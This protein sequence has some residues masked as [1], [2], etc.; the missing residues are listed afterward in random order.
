MLIT[1]PVQ[2]TF[3]TIFALFTCSPHCHCVHFH[4]LKA[5]ISSRNNHK[6][7]LRNP[8]GLTYEDYKT[9]QR[10][11]RPKQVGKLYYFLK[12]AFCRSTPS[13]LTFHNKSPGHILCVT[14]DQRQLSQI[15][16]IMNSF[17]TPYSQASFFNFYVIYLSCPQCV[18]ASNHHSTLQFIL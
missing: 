2:D 12:P 5:A 4:C 16:I 1:L 7:S 15:N 8:E 6:N 11:R 3:K 13:V 17:D 9:T 14:V 18:K 10:L